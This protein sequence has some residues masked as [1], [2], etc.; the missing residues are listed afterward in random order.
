LEGAEGMM[1]RGLILSTL[2]RLKQVCNH[3]AHFLAD[4]SPVR[5]APA[6]WPA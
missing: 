3:P 5:A 2:L 4:H 1:S 6:N